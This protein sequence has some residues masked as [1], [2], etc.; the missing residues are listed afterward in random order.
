MPKF[1]IYWEVE[2]TFVPADPEERL[3][4]WVTMTE[5][6]K[7][8]MVAGVLKDWG[9]RSGMMSGYGITS[10]ISVIELDQLLLKWMPYIKFQ[11]NPVLTADQNIEALKKVAEMMKK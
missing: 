2:P 4:L 1:F 6:V 9:I 8:D 7:A 10:D 11:T 5:M 3:K